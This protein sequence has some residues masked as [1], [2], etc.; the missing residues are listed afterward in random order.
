MVRATRI[1]LA[2]SAWK[3]DEGELTSPSKS[4]SAN[5]YERMKFAGDVGDD[6]RHLR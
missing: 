4:L 2:F 1:E 5:G 3:P 6:A